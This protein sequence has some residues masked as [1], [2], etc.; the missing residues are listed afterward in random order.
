[1]TDTAGSRLVTI[2]QTHYFP[3]FSSCSCLCFYFCCTPGKPILFLCSVTVPL[4]LLLLY[5]LQSHCF[6]CTP[7]CLTQWTTADVFRCLDSL[8][9][10]TTWC[11]QAYSVPHACWFAT[12]SG[13]KKHGRR[14]GARRQKRSA[15]GRKQLRGQLPR[16]LQRQKLPARLKLQPSRYVLCLCSAAVH[17]F[18]ISLL[19]CYYNAYEHVLMLR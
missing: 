11:T 15:S 1:M 19:Y 16:R 7:A 12:G 9:Q 10:F 6:S 14:P 3:V 5:T 18:V 17:V 13:G 8:L 2:V 4:F